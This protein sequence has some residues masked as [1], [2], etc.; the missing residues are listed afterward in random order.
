MTMPKVLDARLARSQ[1]HETH[2]GHG[3]LVRR[4]RLGYKGFRRVCAHV[5]KELEIQRPP[6]SRGLFVAKMSHME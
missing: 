6:R 2:S 5:R 3:D 1:K 4:A